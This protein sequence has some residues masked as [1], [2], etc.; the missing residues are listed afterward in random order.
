MALIVQMI[1]NNAFDSK[2]IKEIC[3]YVISQVQRFQAE[4]LDESLEDFR[5]N[6]IGYIDSEIP[7][8]ILFTY[9]FQEMFERLENVL[10][11]TKEVKEDPLYQAYTKR[12]QELRA[13]DN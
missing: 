1:D 5:S 3:L 6:I 8:S 10:Q 12:L 7:R 2:S 9:F 4:Y 11:D 13:R